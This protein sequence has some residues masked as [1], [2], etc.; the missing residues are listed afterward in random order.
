MGALALGALVAFILPMS[1]GG[2]DGAWMSNWTS[3]GTIRPSTRS[4]GLLFSVPTFLG[5]GLAFRLFFNW[6]RG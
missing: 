4:P 2:S 5:S 1:L 3:W 6:H